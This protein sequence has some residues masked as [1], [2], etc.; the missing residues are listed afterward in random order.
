[1]DDDNNGPPNN[2]EGGVEGG[3]WQPMSALR[4]MATLNGHAMVVVAALDDGRGRVARL[5]RV[6]GCKGTDAPLPLLLPPIF[7]KCFLQI[8]E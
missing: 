1:M 3:W 2:I 6:H 7:L 5:V 4:S 8:L